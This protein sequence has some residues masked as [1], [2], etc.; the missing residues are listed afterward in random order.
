MTV[1][2][3]H[4]HQPRAHEAQAHVTQHAHRPRGMED[5]AIAH[6]PAL[7]TRIALPACVSKLLQPLRHI[8]G[9]GT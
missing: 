5:L 7:H 9:C 2:P 8:H 3:R 6:R 4:I 1:Q